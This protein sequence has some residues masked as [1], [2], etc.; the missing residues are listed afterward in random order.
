MA[1]VAVDT[2]TGKTTVEKMTLV[3]DVGKINNRLVVDGQI[4]GGLAQ[5]IGLAL[6][7]DFEDIKKHSTMLGAGFPYIKQIPDDMELIYVEMPRA[8]RPLRR[9]RCRRTAADLPAC[10]DHQ[11]HLQRLRGAHHPPAGPAGEGAGRTE[12]VEQP[13]P[14][15]SCTVRRVLYC[16]CLPL[17]EEDME[18]KELRDWEA[19]CIQEEPPACRA[20][21]P[22]GVDARAFS[23]AMARDD[24]AGAT[25]NSGKEHAACRHR[26]PVSARP[27]ARV[28]VMRRPSG[29]SDR[30]RRPWNG[31]A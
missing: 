17:R 2:T 26:R 5:G 7:E 24:M 10:G 31:S 29:R 4:Y 21:C 18:Q 27:P 19:Q 30:H 1:E 12:E 14:P 3:A 20:G 8:R 13:S 22:L 9:R 16:F 23:L 25:G 15:G 28:I 6:S 11:R